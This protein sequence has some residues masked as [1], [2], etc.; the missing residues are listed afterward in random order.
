[1]YLRIYLA[2]PETHL[3]IINN[4]EI[5]LMT[6]KIKIKLTWKLKV[7]MI[8]MLKQTV[9]LLAKLPRSYILISNQMNPNLKLI[10]KSMI[11]VDILIY[12]IRNLFI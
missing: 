2:P 5:H 4:L 3:N 9:L 8:N 6:P 12:T 7:I 11:I 10:I 1:M